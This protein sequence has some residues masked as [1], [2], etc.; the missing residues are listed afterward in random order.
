MNRSYK[1]GRNFI[2][3]AIILPLMTLLSILIYRE[4]LQ[5]KETVFTIIQEH[6][7]HEKVSL[8]EN[9]SHY[10]TQKLGENIQQVLYNNP[11]SHRHHEEELS[12]LKGPEIKY[13]YLLYKDEED[14]FRYLLDT[15]TNIDEKAELNQKFDPQTDIWNKSYSDKKFQ[16][17]KQLDLQTLWITIAYPLVVD[18]KVV[19]VLGAD[20]TYDVYQ[21]IVNILKPM[22][23][24]YMY[25]S[26]FMIIMLIVAYIL[27]YLYYINRKRS[28]ID[29]LTK[30]YNRQ[31]L[32]EYLKTSSLEHYQLMM[33]DLDH[34][35]QI[36]DNYGHDVGDKVLISVVEQIKQNIRQ[37]DILVRFGGEEFLVLIYKQT[38]ETCLT[39]AERI[40]NTVM[41][42][43]IEAVNKHILMTISIGINPFPFYAKNFDEAVKIADEQLY[44]AKVSGRNCVKVSEEVNKKQSQTSKRIGDVKSAIDEN[45]ILCAYQ[46]IVST[47]NAQTQKYE[48]LLR[49]LDTGGSIVSP[50]EFLPAIRHTNVYI[51]VTKIVID[52]AIKTLKENSFD[53]SMNLDLQDILNDDIMNLIKDEFAENPE[54]RKRLTI[55]ILEHEEITNFDIIKERIATLKELGFKIAIDD[56]GSGYAN[57][58]Y[59]LHLEIDILKI[60][61]SLIRDIDTNKNSYHIVETIGGFAKKMGIKTVAEQIETV[62]E[63][64]CI[65]SLNI[66][67]VQ[68]YLLG[69]PSF[70]FDSSPTPQ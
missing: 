24:I 9:Y 67:Y 10:L 20:F 11:D 40:R 42:H 58:Q 56:F 32:N 60:D 51:N 27:I 66:D 30:I 45:R 36:N 12:L 6:L 34:F 18:D 21:Q 43:H 8:L 62:N 41:T 48:M 29:P 57:F 61:G 49:L 70:E 54:L 50:L 26:I 13:L 28:F 14:K 53:L 39:I 63:L 4:Y 22:E 1:I 44:N 5:T 16:I 55:E 2:I 3:F 38:L 23:K 19:A 64:K 31:Y 46:P 59:L 69:K 65:K 47:Q 15:T 68:G 35:K 37:E 7:I 52:F 25:V 17:T 33:I